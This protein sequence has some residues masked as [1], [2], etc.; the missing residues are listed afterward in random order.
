MLAG[1]WQIGCISQSHRLPLE[2][3][4]H[5]SSSKELSVPLVLRLI[6]DNLGATSVQSMQIELPIQP[7]GRPM[8]QDA[9]DRLATRNWRSPWK[10]GAC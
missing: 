6:E 9:A 10:T 8:A 7:E 4:G 3:L 2:G 1:L 5:E